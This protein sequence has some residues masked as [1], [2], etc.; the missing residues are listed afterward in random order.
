M[1]FIYIL[2]SVGVFAATQLLLLFIIIYIAITQENYSILSFVVL[3]E[4]IIV[5]AD[6]VLF[7]TIWKNTKMTQIQ[8]KYDFLK[9]QK[10]KELAYYENIQQKH[11][12]VEKIREELVCQ[13]DS[14]YSRLEAEDDSKYDD[15]RLM[16]N[17]LQDNIDQIKVDYF[18]ENPVVNA[19]L[20]DWKAR[21]QKKDINISITVNIPEK[22]AITNYDICSVFSN[23]LS[24]AVEACERAAAQANKAIA[25]KA[26]VKGNYLYIKVTN[27]PVLAEDIDGYKTKKSD[28]G[29]HGLG[30]GI[31]KKTAEKY[32][33]QLTLEVEGN[34]HIALIALMI[35]GRGGGN[36]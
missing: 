31:L 34:A 21:A 24:N 11:D 14:I 5:I 28:S 26:V 9:Q 12:E 2:K 36:L 8:D 7:K 20:S 17:Q 18:C 19:L 13:L 16:L 10:Q 32:K 15:V 30:I 22:L 1:R 23:L 35:S 29:N 25:V 3:G 27:S 33:G 4:V 6:I